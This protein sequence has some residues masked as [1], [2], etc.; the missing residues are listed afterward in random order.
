MKSNKSDAKT[1]Q[2]SPNIFT[3][4]HNTLLATLRWG[5]QD[6]DGR[7]VNPQEGG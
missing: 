1:T 2:V 3:F 7:D 4:H 6:F 5:C